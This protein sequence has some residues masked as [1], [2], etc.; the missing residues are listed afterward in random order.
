[1]A[2]HVPSDETD[3]KITEINK[4]KIGWKANTCMLQT[5]HPDYDHKECSHADEQISL[6]QTFSHKDEEKAKF[7]KKIVSR[8][9]MKKSKESGK[10]LPKNDFP[11]N[12]TKT[13]TKVHS[14]RKKYKDISEIPD[15]V[16]PDTWDWRN[17]DGYDFTSEIYDQAACGSCYMAAMI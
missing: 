8:D 9:K 7:I 5:S 14:F 17:I 10:K 11:E 3:V 15:G 16:L 13:I 6:A 1:M 12:F 2:E 4:K